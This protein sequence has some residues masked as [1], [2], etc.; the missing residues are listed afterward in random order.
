MPACKSCGAPV[1]WVKLTTGTSMPL[2]ARPA[3]NG[4]VLRD[5]SRAKVLGPEES[6]KLRAAGIGLY[7]SHFATCPNARQHRR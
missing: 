5:K 3:D 4:N 2:D 6:E 1:L 7:L